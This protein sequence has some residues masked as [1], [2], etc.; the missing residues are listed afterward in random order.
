[1]KKTIVLRGIKTEIDTQFENE[2]GVYGDSFWSM[3]EDNRY[4]PQTFDFIKKCFVPGSKFI[5]V[6]AA[7]GCMTIYA[8]QLGYHVLAIEPQTKVFAALK[9]NLDLNPEIALKV[10]ALHALVV[11]M[12][13]QETSNLEDYFT[14]GAS[15]PLAALDT[16]INLIHL[17]SLISKIGSNSPITIKMDIE[18][19]EF[20]I[21][22]NIQLLTLLKSRTANMYLSLHPGF[23]NPLK[24][25]N[26][27]VKFIWRLRAIVEVGN[28][29]V[30]LSRFARI[31]DATRTTRL[32]L[33]TI[34]I[35]LR[36]N[37]RDFHIIFG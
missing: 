34:L 27:F 26:V 35:R 24:S 29:V 10:E 28:L 19:V 1:M 7:T 31:Y 14:E 9:R 32:N 23:L 22:Q 3:V 15:G 33:V 30:R 25:G 17:E 21:L 11:D 2:L 12:R 20:N 13:D 37:S 18:G 16:N 4:E 8:A 6:G 5:D 36:K